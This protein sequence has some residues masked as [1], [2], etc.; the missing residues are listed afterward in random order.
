MPTREIVVNDHNLPLA[1]STY[2]YGQRFEQFVITEIFRL[3]HYR[4]A[5]YALSYLRT[6]DDAEIDLI[7]ERPGVPTF[8][9]E[10]KSS[11]RVSE[12][13]VRSVATFA[14]DLPKSVP[15]CLSRDKV[16]RT[17][18]GVKCLPW[19]KGIAELGLG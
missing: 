13:D 15:L 4:K 14:A 8:L 19:R 7:V 16:S 17:I 6:K 12:D 9:I 2:E 5:D 10:I 3:N 18:R 11:R 1:D